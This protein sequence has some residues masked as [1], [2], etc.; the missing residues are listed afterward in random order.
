[1]FLANE[2]SFRR[3][4][5]DLEQPYGYNGWPFD[6]LGST[7]ENTDD[8]EGRACALRVT[9]FS[10]ARTWRRVGPKGD[11]RGGGIPRWV[12]VGGPEAVPK[13]ICQ[14]EGRDNQC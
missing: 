6:N 14:F 10:G 12:I 7:K 11:H 3:L 1:M 8:A 5:R 4:Q 9:G 13:W 2:A